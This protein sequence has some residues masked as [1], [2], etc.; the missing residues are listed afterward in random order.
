MNPWI[1]EETDLPVAR[2]GMANGEPSV[3]LD[4][5]DGGSH[6]DDGDPGSDDW[7]GPSAIFQGPNKALPIRWL[8]EALASVEA[9]PE[10]PTWPDGEVM[11]VA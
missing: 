11:H 3:M 10:T 4:M 7:E 8:R 2:W 6:S 1:Y 5:P 9:L